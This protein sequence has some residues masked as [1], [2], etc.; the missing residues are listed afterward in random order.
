[1]CQNNNQNAHAEDPNQNHR[2]QAQALQAK[3]D[4]IAGLVGSMNQCQALNT[5]AAEKFG[6]LSDN[7]TAML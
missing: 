4:G 2:G 5:A 1:M 6:V 3:A 7:V